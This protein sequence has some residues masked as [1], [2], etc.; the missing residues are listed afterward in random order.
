LDNLDVNADLRQLR[1]HQF[2]DGDGGGEDGSDQELQ[3]EAVSVSGVGKELLGPGDVPSVERDFVQW[4]G[5]LR[6]GGGDGARRMSTSEERHV[7]DLLAVDP[8]GNRL[9]DAFI[10]QLRWFPVDEQDVVVGRRLD[11]GRDIRVARQQIEHLGV[12]EHRELDFTGAKGRDP[13]GLVG[14]DLPDHLIEVGQ[15]LLPVVGEFA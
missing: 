11:D 12:L 13:S 10:A 14:H 7:L 5:E 6:E 1:L 8:E 9:A 3:L 4:P 2:G 15:I